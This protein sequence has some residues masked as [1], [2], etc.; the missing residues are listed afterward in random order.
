MPTTWKPQAS[1]QSM[2]ECCSAFRRL[3]FDSIAAGPRCISWQGPFIGGQ[4]LGKG[5]DSSETDVVRGFERDSLSTA[6]K[7]L[8]STI[9]LGELYRT[10]LVDL[11]M[12]VV[13]NVQVQKSAAK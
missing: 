2:L 11:K 5:N 9:E 4:S 6:E 3:F 12:D 1:L 13:V 8:R 7:S 10:T